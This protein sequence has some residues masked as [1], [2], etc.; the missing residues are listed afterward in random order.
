M[1]ERGRIAV[2]PGEGQRPQLV[3]AVPCNPKETPL[4]ASGAREKFAD[5]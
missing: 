3:S 4:P 2:T 1:L 5:A